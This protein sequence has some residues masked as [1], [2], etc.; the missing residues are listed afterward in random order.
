MISIVSIDILIN[1]TL[2]KLIHRL[3]YIYGNINS[4]NFSC[5]RVK[6][7]YLYVETAYKNAHLTKFQTW[8]NLYVVTFCF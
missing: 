1:V 2:I 4:T 7:A 6:G 3:I 5:S 8:T